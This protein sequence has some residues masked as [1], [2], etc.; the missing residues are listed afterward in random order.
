M[1]LE[2]MSS[3]RSDLN[4]F[5]EVTTERIKKFNE[6]INNLVK[7][8]DLKYKYQSIIL[9]DYLDAYVSHTE[10]EMEK[11]NASI[12]AS[13]RL[14]RPINFL[15]EKA[16]HKYVG[17]EMGKMKKIYIIDDSFPTGPT[18]Y[19]SDEKMKK[20]RSMYTSVI[21][22]H[23]CFIEI[24]NEFKSEYKLYKVS[25]SIDEEILRNI[26]KEF[27]RSLIKKQKDW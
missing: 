13:L 3:L 1:F 16:P 14:G 11:I 10:E 22:D 12:K 6:A 24:V 27:V 15:S 5:K 23:P 25:L 18:E 7:N 2:K 17:E 9:R 20:A 21:Q 8:I 19:F 26:V 4:I